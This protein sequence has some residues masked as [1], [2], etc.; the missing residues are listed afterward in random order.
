MGRQWRARRRPAERERLCRGLE[1]EDAY[2]CRGERGA[3]CCPG[4]EGDADMGL[5]WRAWRRPGGRE[6][7]ERG[8]GGSWWRLR[9]QER[10]E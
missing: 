10:R 7:W 4:G 1:M 2:W 9:E 3:R 5:W 8:P 6:R